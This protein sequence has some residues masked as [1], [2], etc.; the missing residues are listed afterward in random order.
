MVW[1]SLVWFDMVEGWLNYHQLGIELI[2]GLF[3]S[4]GNLFAMENQHS[5]WV[6]HLPEAIFLEFPE[7]NYA[8]LKRWSMELGCIPTSKWLIS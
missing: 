3:L 1:I 5:Y 7:G 2:S 8:I 4:S 6:N